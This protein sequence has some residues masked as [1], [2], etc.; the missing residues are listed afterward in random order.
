MIQKQKQKQKQSNIVNKP[1]T[2]QTTVVDQV[3]IQVIIKG[4]IENF[5]EL[6][7]ILLKAKFK[8]HSIAY[9]QT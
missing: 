6:P 7:R 8:M 2:I 1:Y 9:T 5:E 3:I 4:K